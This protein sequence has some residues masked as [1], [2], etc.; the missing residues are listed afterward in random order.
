M[1][2]EKHPVTLA[3][4]KEIVDKLEEKEEI[5][6]FLK[7][8]SKLSKDKAEKLA[9]EIRGLKN[10]K[11]REED[12]IKVVDFLPKTAEDVNK[13]FTEMTLGEDE[14]NAILEIVKKY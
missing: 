12:T 2:L 4:A 8:F 11:I 6:K 13:I 7:K 1:I 3:E 9:E 5:K 14:I 10:Q